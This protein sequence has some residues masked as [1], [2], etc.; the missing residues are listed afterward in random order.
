MLFLESMND[1]MKPIQ[2]VVDALRGLPRALVPYEIDP[3]RRP[4]I[5]GTVADGASGA[6]GVVDVSDQ[7]DYPNWVEAETWEPLDRDIF[8]A[9]E[10]PKPNQAPVGLDA[11]AWYVSFHF[12]NSG[13]W[14]IF[15]PVSSLGYFEMRVFQELTASRASKWRLAYDALLAH[16]QMHFAVDYACAQWELLLHAPCWAGLRNRIRSERVPYLEVEEKLANAFMLQCASHWKEKQIERGL[17]RFVARQPVGYRDG[18]VATEQTSFDHVAAEAIKTYVGLHAAERGLNVT[19]PAFDH[20]SMLP[21][22]Q[23]MAECP[24]HIIHDETRIGLPVPAVRLITRICNIRETE[25]FQRR[26]ARLDRSVQR[27]WAAMKQKLSGGVPRSARLEKMK[28]SKDDVFSVR[29]SDNFRV[30][31]QPNGSERWNAVDI[32]S[33]KEMGH[34]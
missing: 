20:A 5:Q 18:L 16:E 7:A 32:G 17:R 34:E 26:F 25:Q 31:L 10:L 3:W 14:G 11:L 4:V 1:Q 21:T 30:H 13:K 23:G 15:I 29:V 24:V 27:S 2:E 6:E 28:G 33:H 12:A 8:G 22:R 9:S 19:E